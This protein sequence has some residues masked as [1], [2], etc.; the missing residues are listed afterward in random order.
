MDLETVHEL[1]WNIR[2]GIGNDCHG[3]GATMYRLKLPEHVVNLLVQ[4]RT[5]PAQ[6]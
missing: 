1:R 4:H 5:E 2:D 3:T 6:K